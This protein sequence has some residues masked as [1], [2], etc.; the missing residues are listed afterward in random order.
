VPTGSWGAA[1][2]AQNFAAAGN[3][4]INLDARTGHRV[5]GDRN[6]A[7]RAHLLDFLHWHFN[8]E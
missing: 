4:A 5:A 8:L 7:F 2:A 1:T 6:D 3:F